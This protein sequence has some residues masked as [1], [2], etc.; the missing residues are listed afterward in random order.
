MKKLTNTVNNEQGFVLVASLM[1]LMI[2]LV[3]GIA[4]TNTTTIEL[5]ISGNDKL[6]KQVFYQAEGVVAETVREIKN[7]EDNPNLSLNSLAWLHSEAALAGRL[8]PATEQTDIHDDAFWTANAAV[9]AL[10][11][12]G[13]LQRIAAHRGMAG[14]YGL[15]AASVPHDFDVYG[16]SQQNNAFSGI[17]VGCQIPISQ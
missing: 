5:Q 10:P 6:S 3:I 13:L 15:G 2:L 8:A 7:T 1:M 14:G 17:K 12:P 4:A 16:R 9:S 11:T